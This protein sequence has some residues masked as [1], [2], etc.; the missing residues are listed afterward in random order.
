MVELI[1]LYFTVYP[2]VVIIYCSCNL[3]FVSLSSLRLG[4]ICLLAAAAAGSWQ[5][6]M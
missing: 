2:M 6:L 3:E 4:K 1:L 5:R